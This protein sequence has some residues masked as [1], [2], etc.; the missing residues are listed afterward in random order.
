MEEGDIYRVLAGSDLIL[1]LNAY[2]GLQI[3]DF[4]DV[5]NPKIIGDLRVSGTPVEMYSVGDRVYVL[6]N[7]WRG[8]W[9][10]REDVAVDTFHG[11]IVLAIDVSDRTNPVITGQATIPGNIR[12]SRLTRGNGEEALFVVT[13]EWNTST[14]YVQSYSVSSGG[15][16]A[17]KSRIDLDTEG[18]LTDI[19]ASPELLMVARWDWNQR[20]QGSEVSLIDIS[21]PNG[22]M[23]EGATIRASGFVEK[24]TNMDHD[25]DIVRIVSGNDW[26]NQ[27]NTN[28]VQTFNVADITNPVPVDAETFG[29][30]ENLYATIFV[31]EKAFFV[32]YRRVDPFH[33]FSIDATG[34]IE[35]KSEFI[36]SGWNDFFK[37]VSAN[38]RLIG[39]GYNDENGTRD[40]S[41]SLY[42]IED[43]VNPNPLVDREGVELQWGWSEATWDDRA[44]T[45]L[46]K[47]TS[48]MAGDVLETG[49]V[50][51]PFSGWDGDGYTSGVQIFTFS[52]TSLTRRG[53]MVH[54][55]PVRRSFEADDGLTANLSE[56]ELSL[57]GTS[58][59]ANP[60]AHGRVE[61]AP[62][63]TDV[64][65]F[66]DYA[67]RVNQKS[68]YYYGWYT[69]EE[70]PASIVEIIPRSAHPDTAVAVSSVEV[71]ANAQ[72]YAAGDQLVAVTTTVLDWNV[73]P[74]QYETRV[75]TFDLSDP[76]VP[77]AATATS[78]TT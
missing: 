37:P 58:D 3:I 75:R 10:S 19:Q 53:L 6:M 62:N 7:N 23:V 20:G 67:A 30:G 25:G 16:L 36:V 40:L 68:D 52:E 2:R 64:L 21:N 55:T 9:G 65:V 69:A 33:A 61:L 42:D 34:Q 13:N 15:R 28:H 27:T 74:Y 31:E 22:T 46:E 57:F 39:I 60:V 29:D 45:V 8:Y 73:Y 4:S 24:K 35:E 11:G 26:S 47:G 41:V 44:F 56:A 59:A 17:A 49:L 72:L 71:P 76:T 5:A 77:V 14:T 66:G 32:T 1:N 48:V 43:L 78:A 70:P 50:L 18:Y 12:T 51:L 63:Y 54:G 38:K